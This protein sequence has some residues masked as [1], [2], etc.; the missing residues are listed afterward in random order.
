MRYLISLLIVL[1]SC[2]ASLGAMK[3]PRGGGV[4]A[5]AGCSTPANGDMLSEGFIGTGYENSWTKTEGTAEIDP[6]WTL[7]GTPPTAACTEGFQVDAADGN[8]R[9]SAESPTFTTID[10]T[11]TNSDIYFYL[12]VDSYTLPYDGKGLVI[13]VPNTGANLGTTPG[14]IGI[15]RDA[16]ALR[17]RVRGTANVD[18]PISIDTWY[19]VRVHYDT[20]AASSYIN[21][22]GGTNT[23]FTRN[24]WTY[25]RVHLGAVDLDNNGDMTN[26][27]VIDFEVG[28][29]WVNTP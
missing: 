5:V 13:L 12:Y 8:T 27:S 17:L 14:W 1:L 18:I 2:S 23:N 29:I 15:F 7:S 24:D 25:N 19:Y 10:P 3:A 20:T 11:T 26:S 4:A 21:L 28:G 6:D 22:D 16:G 9:E